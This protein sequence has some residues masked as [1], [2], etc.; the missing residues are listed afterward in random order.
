MRTIFLT[1]ALACLLS[2]NVSTATPKVGDR[3]PD[4]SGFD[5]K[6]KPFSLR[7]KLAGKPAVIVF[8]CLT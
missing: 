2:A 3:L 8:G 5:E 6:G 7:E 4:V 1:S